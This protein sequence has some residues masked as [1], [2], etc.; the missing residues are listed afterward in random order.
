MLDAQAAVHMSARAGGSAAGGLEPIHVDLPPVIVEGRIDDVECICLRC[1]S[2]FLSKVIILPSTIDPRDPESGRTFRQARTPELCPDC[3]KA[4]DDRD[5]LRREEEERRH[6]ALPNN[7]QY[8]QRLQAVG[9]QD[10]RLWIAT[11][12]NYDAGECP[13]GLASARRFVTALLNGARPSPSWLFLSGPTGTGKT[14][15]LVGIDRALWVAGY[16]GEVV[17]DVAPYAIKR[18]QQGYATNESDR[19]IERRVRAAVWLCDD[20]GRG[21]QTNDR[22][23]IITE[24]AALR[25][26]MP[27]VLTSNYTAQGLED[28]H[29]EYMTLASRLGGSVCETPAMVGR[30]RREG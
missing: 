6:R 7:R 24:I 3:R 22:V 25:G 19:M 18:I 27:T 29:E 2:E 5:R 17:L 28:R 10:E 14:H 12:E 11:L 20:L 8:A 16:P 26:G 4:D 30:D 21:S 9:I 23:Q 1:T 13:E 15:L